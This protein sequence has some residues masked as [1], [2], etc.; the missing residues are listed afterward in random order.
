MTPPR[1]TKAQEKALLWLPVDGSYAIRPG[2]VAAALNSLHL[3]HAS[4]VEI[5]DGMFGRRGAYCSR[6]RLTPAG[7]A[8]R[9]ELEKRD[10]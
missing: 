9:K 3:Y 10:D 2:P 5:E 7:I 8:A 6:Y 1:L 4:L